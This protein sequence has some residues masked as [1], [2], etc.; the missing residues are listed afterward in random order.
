MFHIAQ[1]CVLFLQVRQ[2]TS[3]AVLVG[4]WLLLS[5]WRNV[6][7]VRRVHADRGRGLVRRLRQRTE[8]KLARSVVL[9]SR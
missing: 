6:M 1:M 8:N 9:H 7:V 4:N 2:L 5:V 3:I